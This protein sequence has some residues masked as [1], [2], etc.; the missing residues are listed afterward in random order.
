MADAQ[1]QKT[2][3]TAQGVAAPSEKLWKRPQP[4]VECHVCRSSRAGLVV[5]LLEMVGLNHSV[6]GSSL[7]WALITFAS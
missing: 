1:H 6:A 5:K 4:E 7:L 3:L 2:Q